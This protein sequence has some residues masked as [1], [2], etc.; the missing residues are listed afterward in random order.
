MNRPEEQISQSVLGRYELLVNPFPILPKHFTIASRKHQQQTIHGHYADMLSIADLMP[1]MMIFYNGPHC[2]ASAPD[3]MHFQAVPLMEVNPVSKHFI[4]RA[5]SIEESEA[6][7]AK[8]E[9]DETNIL[10]WKDGNEFVTVVIP[11]S[12]HRPDCYGTDDGSFLVSL[13]ALDMAGL[14]ITPRLEDFQRLTPEAIAS[15]LKECGK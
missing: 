12:K 14:I 9:D 15:I 2:G 11:R 5:T 6:Q 8:Y 4:I 3:H 1:G 7:F 10:A 13:G